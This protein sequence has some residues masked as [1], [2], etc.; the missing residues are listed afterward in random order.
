MRETLYIVRRG[1]SDHRCYGRRCEHYFV[2]TP[3]GYTLSDGF[4]SQEA[5][6]SLAEQR[7]YARWVK[8]PA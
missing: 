8:T 7:G 6:E 5:A 3:D 4:D 1:R 2:E